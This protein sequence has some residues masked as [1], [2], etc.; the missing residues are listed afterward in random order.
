MARSR[1]I[2][3]LLVLAFV[4]WVC[5]GMVLGAQAGHAIA[6]LAF[7]WLRFAGRTLP[8]AAVNWSGWGMVAICSVVSLALLRCFTKSTRRSAIIFGAVWILFAVTV[9]AAGLFTRAQ[10]L[11]T[12]KEPLL[13]P[14]KSMFV[15]DIKSAILGVIMAAQDE[16]GN[17]QK[18]RADL[19]FYDGRNRWEEMAVTVI[20]DSDGK[21]IG[22]AVR[23]HEPK[24]NIGI[25]VVADGFSG[26][27]GPEWMGAVMAA[28]A[29]VE[30]AESKSS[31]KDQF[32]SELAPEVRASM[33]TDPR[34][35]VS[36]Y[37]TQARQNS[38]GR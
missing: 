22:A 35:E 33:R 26:V 8:E 3:L 28:L 29:E 25:V 16:G 21:V 1:F 20:A 38:A 17:A 37:F 6:A 27:F 32:F 31:F 19:H 15:H 24:L 34:L 10:H 9:A 23:P 7:G 2:I 11:A 14:R 36:A 18:V 4:I 12:L 30:G 13:L 5:F